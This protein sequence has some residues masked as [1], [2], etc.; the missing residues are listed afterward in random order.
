MSARIR[1]KP[2]VRSE[3]CYRHRWQLARLAACALVLMAWPPTFSDAMISLAPMVETVEGAPGSRV[4]F[5]LRVRNGAK[6]PLRC[7]ALAQDLAMT[8]QGLPHGADS[9][10][11][12]GAGAWLSFRPDQFSL[13]SG[14]TQAV[15]CTVAFPRRTSGGYY[16]IAAILGRPVQPSAAPSSGGVVRFSYQSNCLV[17]AVAKGGRQQVKLKALAI[18]LLPSESG[19]TVQWR[20]AVRVENT[21]NIHGSAEGTA[22]IRDQTGA[23]LWSGPVKSGKGLLVP[24][25]P[26]VFEGQS[27]VQ[28]GDGQYVVGAELQT[29]NPRSRMRTAQTFNISRGQATRAGQ[30]GPIEAHAGAILLGSQEVFIS[31]RAGSRRAG[32]MTV[33]NV[34]DEDLSCTVSV[35]PWTPPGSRGAKRANASAEWLT[36]APRTFTLPIRASTRIRI[37]AAIPKQATGEYYAS[38][39][40]SPQ[41]AGREAELPVHFLIAVHVEGTARQSV[42]ITGAGVKPAEAGLRLWATIRN[43]GTSR[44]RP[45]ATA[46][47]V[48]TKGMSVGEAV[49]L[50][51]T[52]GQTEGMLFPGESRTV[53]VDWPRAVPPGQYELS[54]DVRVADKSLSRRSVRFSLPLNATKRS[55]RESKPP[56]RPRPTRR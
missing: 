52:G 11:P 21:G 30:Q 22:E 47:V 50:A 29:K 46:R 16:A 26:R 35:Q 10:G 2:T 23:R 24:G 5:V 48:D 49:S 14:A 18:E 42:S 9:A 41:V 43:D 25:F 51:A 19:K 31:G 27:G 53:A 44:I 32:T 56:A 39:R 8:E 6:Q 17:M 13:A 40:V 7:Q 4:S 54:V 15:T 55:A 33:R 28:L 34:S 38:V 45:D 20:P 3:S 1:M 36:I 37:D 12:R